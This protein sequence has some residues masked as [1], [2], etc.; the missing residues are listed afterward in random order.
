MTDFSGNSR[1]YAQTLTGIVRTRLVNRPHCSPPQTVV[2]KSLQETLKRL[3]R[4]CQRITVYDFYK[5]ILNVSIIFRKIDLQAPRFRGTPLLD[6]GS[7]YTPIDCEPLTRGIFYTLHFS[8]S[9]PSVT[10]PFRV[11]D[12]HRIFKGFDFFRR[13]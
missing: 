7:S 1:M 11:T 3:P 8:N 10:R 4:V 12:R 2:L 9:Y 6:S 5:Q 13:T